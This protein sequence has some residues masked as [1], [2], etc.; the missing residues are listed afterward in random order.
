MGCDSQTSIL[1][2]GLTVLVGEGSTSWCDSWRENSALR[3]GVKTYGWL[4]M[5]GPDRN[6]SIVSAVGEFSEWPQQRVPQQADLGQTLCTQRINHYSHATPFFDLKPRRATR[7]QYG[8]HSVG[9]F[10]L[11]GLWLVRI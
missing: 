6:A 7:K 3:A 11:L 4:G 8:A 9:A 1:A 2:P 10:G 5:P